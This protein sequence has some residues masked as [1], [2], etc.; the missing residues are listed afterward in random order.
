M[1][2]KIVTTTGGK[3]LFDKISSPLLKELKTEMKIEKFSD[4]EIA[5]KFPNSIR[6]CH[7]FM[8][9]EVSKPENL[10]ELMLA[11]NAAFLAAG[12]KVT[13]IIPYFGYSRQD[14][15]EGPRG[16]LGAAMVAKMITSRELS[17]I[18]DR[19]VTVDLHAEQEQGFFNT[20]CEHLRGHSFF[21]DSI[22]ELINEKTILCS[23]D[24]GGIK[25]VEKYMSKLNLPSVMIS[26]RREKPNEIASMRLYGDVKG[27]E[28]IIIDDIVD[29]CGTLKTAVLYLKEQGAEKVFF[30]GTHAV[31]SGK[32]FQNLSE[33][34]LDKLIISDT[35]DLTKKENMKLE[36]IMPTIQ[37]ISCMPKI[38]QMIINLINSTS[39][40][41]LS[42]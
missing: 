27:K 42:N 4:S 14:R 22:R 25:R 23:P 9:A 15:Q 24:A 37:T 3:H 36:K 41:E 17:P 32:A 33:S 21:L 39:I 38:E 31:L 12:E 35:V 18:V 13:V 30:V 34:N 16:S 8:F 10:M 19:V 40:S 1:K 6:G 7:V 2:Y 11:L 5:V 29:T 20:P 26:K 28:V